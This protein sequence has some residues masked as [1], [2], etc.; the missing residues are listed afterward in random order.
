MNRKFLQKFTVIGVYFSLLLGFAGFSYAQAAAP[1]S[2]LSLIG[3]IRSDDFAG[4]VIRAGNE[5]TFYRLGDKLPDG[6]Q[7]IKVRPDTILLKGSDGMTYEMY[8]LHETKSVGA[9]AQAQNEPSPTAQ[10]TMP[11][12]IQ[13]NPGEHV[14]NAYERRRLKRLGIRGNSENDDE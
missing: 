12:T 9:V 5:Q 1:S 13:R 14:M 6:S 7:I 8:I 3:T 11:Q 4:A 2:G 10:Q